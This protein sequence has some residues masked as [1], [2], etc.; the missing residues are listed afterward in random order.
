VGGGTLAARRDGDEQPND[1]E[2]DG[3]RG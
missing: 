2:T 3:T 1:E